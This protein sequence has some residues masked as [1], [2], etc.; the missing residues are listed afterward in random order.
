M[1]TQVS[2]I[3]TFLARPGGKN[4]AR[5]LLPCSDLHPAFIDPP[6]APLSC[7][8]PELAPCSLPP[9]ATGERDCCITGGKDVGHGKKCIVPSWKC[10]VRCT[11]QLPGSAAPLCN[12][13]WR[14]S[15]LLYRVHPLSCKLAPCTKQPCRGDR[16]TRQ[17][18]PR[19]PAPLLSRVVLRWFT[20]RALVPT[21]CSREG[22]QTHASSRCSGGG[23]LRS[24]L[25]RILPCQHP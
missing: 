6:A 3:R 17:P 9:P 13:Q 20:P 7:A 4:T 12:C 11:W 23:A 15:S 5:S 21:A 22:L 1:C 25:T 8:N 19:L 2:L 14:R 10:E 16:L 24:G 18:N